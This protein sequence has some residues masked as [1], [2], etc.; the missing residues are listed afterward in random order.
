MN[1]EK[2]QI[3]CEV[4]MINI[5]FSSVHSGAMHVVSSQTA[6]NL[7]ALVSCSSILSSGG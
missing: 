5:F 3:N 4:C 1:N 7:S 2:C 6:S